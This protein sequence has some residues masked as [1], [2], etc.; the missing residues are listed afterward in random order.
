MFE[1][2]AATLSGGMVSPWGLVLILVLLFAAG[3]V[4]AIAGGGG[5]ISIP[6]YLFAGLPVHTAIG[7]NKL[8]SSMGTTVA[9]IKYIREG[10]M[11]WWLVPIS[12]ACALGGSV[13]GANLSLMADENL[14]KIFMLTV[15]PVAAWYVLRTKRMDVQRPEFTK[16]K[17]LL[18]CAGIAVGMGVYD[19]F[20]GP[21]TGTFL[22]L[23]LPALAHLSLGQAAGLTKAINLSTNVAALVVFLAN[24]TVLIALG[25]VAGVFNIFGNYL[26][27]KAFTTKGAKIVRPMLLLVLVLF[28]GRLI[29]E[30]AGVM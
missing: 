29:L 1:S 5:F 21:G 8:S 23:L 30:L 26:G 24:G 16:K 27:A 9:T 19:G 25:L 18:I 3:F 13:I 4:D 15:I 6:A 2:L 14:I 10:Y 22:M 20:Y 11:V 12:V 17:T 7:T 28:A